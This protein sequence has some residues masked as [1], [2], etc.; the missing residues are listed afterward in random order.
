M[1]EPTIGELPQTKFVTVGETPVYIT[2]PDGQVDQI[3]LKGAAKR[4]ADD[5]VVLIR[6]SSRRRGEDEYL[7]PLDNLNDLEQV[8]WEKVG[9]LQYKDADGEHII[10]KDQISLE[11]PKLDKLDQLDQ[12]DK[13]KTSE[14]TAAR[15]VL[16]NISGAPTLTIVGLKAYETRAHDLAAKSM[17]LKPKEVAN[18]FERLLEIKRSIWKQS[19]GHTYFQEKARQYYLDMLKSADSPFAA[20]SIKLAETAGQKR[21]DELLKNS[22]F[23][24]RTSTRFI[25]YI[26]SN[27]GMRT[28]VQ[29]F[30]MEE[31]GQMRENGQIKEMATFDRESKALRS[32]FEQD[33]DRQD[34]FIRKTLGEK[35]VIADEPIANQIE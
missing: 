11:K 10:L 30:A 32:R 16:E 4:G 8:D 34:N 12:L 23:L 28:I 13:T 31:I 25:D 3:V 9:G 26:K 5:P 19:L 35:L 14:P 20:E 2:K 21:Y 33:F 22:N 17:Q 7:K 29:H 1:P 27:L 6:Q 15:A 24:S 18:I